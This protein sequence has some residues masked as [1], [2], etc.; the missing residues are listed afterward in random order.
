MIWSNPRS[1][2]CAIRSAVPD[3]ESIPIGRAGASLLWTRSVVERSR[4]GSE[5]ASDGPAPSNDGDRWRC[6]HANENLTPYTRMESDNA[7]CFRLFGTKLSQDIIE[8]GNEYTG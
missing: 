3:R 4:L 7:V 8:L 5:K 2:F 6:A 1:N